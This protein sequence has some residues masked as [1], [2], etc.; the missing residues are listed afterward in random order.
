MQKKSKN[1]K[2]KLQK[3]ALGVYIVAKKKGSKILGFGIIFPELEIIFPGL[4]IIFLALGM[5][6]PCLQ[7]ISLSFRIIYPDLGI[8]FPGFK[9]IFSRISF[10]IILEGIFGYSRG[11]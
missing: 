11:I 2:K 5:I 3:K 4:G 1:A 8:I 7:M 10:R 6:F 9:K